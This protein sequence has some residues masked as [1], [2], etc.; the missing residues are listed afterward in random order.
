MKRHT[1][2][3]G[4]HIASFL[5]VLTASAQA[6]F[7]PWGPLVADSWIYFGGSQTRMVIHSVNGG[8]YEVGFDQMRSDGSVRGMNA[9]KFS[10]DGANTGHLVSTDLTGSFDIQNTGNNRVYSD[11]L[12][13][14]AIDASELDPD[15]A[16]SLG[17]HNAVPY[18]FDPITDFG[19]YN[20]P[21]YDAGRPSGYYSQT[22]PSREEISYSF[23]SGMVTLFALEDIGLG[24]YGGSVTVDYAFDNLPGTAVF[25]V[26]GFDEDAVADW[27]YHTNRALID[28]HRP[29][30]PISTFEVV[31]E[32]TVLSLT[33]FGALLL[34]RRRS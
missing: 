29:S 17:L 12:L 9:L 34:A 8:D 18:V 28:D 5:F 32:P 16:M 23:E 14:V 30:A 33:V 3:C 19:Y 22:S 20:H 6:A 2:Q 13:L 1:R 4:T 31:P 10:Y 25:S 21:E 11:L 27:V 7:E 15:F 24:P 26:Y